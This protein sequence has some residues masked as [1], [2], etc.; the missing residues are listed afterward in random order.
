M[1][2][3]WRCPPL[4]LLATVTDIGLVTFFGIDNK[5]ICIGN[6]GCVGYLRSRYAGFAKGDIA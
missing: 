4:S 5:L 2:T 6:L 1:L 3:R